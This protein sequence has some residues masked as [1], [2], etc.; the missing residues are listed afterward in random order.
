MPDFQNKFK[1]FCQIA[2]KVLKSSF[3]SLLNFTRNL[4]PQNFRKSNILELTKKEFYVSKGLF[5]KRVLIMTWQ[6][7]RRNILLSLATV[8]VL[9]LI[10]LVFNITL[11][12]NYLSNQSIKQVSQKI[13]IIVWLKDDANEFSIEALKNDLDNLEETK[14]VIYTTKTEALQTFQKDNPEVYTFIKQY[15]L[16]NPLP[17]SLGIIARDIED[18]FTILEFLKKERYQD[19]VNTDEVK[20]NIEE[21]ERTEK[22][23][24][25]TRFINQSGRYLVGLFFFVFIFITLNTVNMIIN[26]KSRE[27]LIMRLVGAKYAFI[28]LPFILEGMFYAACAFGLGLLL[29]YIFAIQFKNK[30]ASSLLDDSLISGFQNTIE[31][32]IKHFHSILFYEISIAVLTGIFSSYLAIEWYLHKKNLLMD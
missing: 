9:S 30:L 2:K 29:M 3:V 32:F 1:E 26:R 21:R 19:I 20:N 22:V 7:V 6:G 4:H 13:D 15:K 25:I 24:G 17:A 31:L 5:W 10:V 12:V 18:N 14:S 27:I 8:F 28:R 16:D 23:L 11:A